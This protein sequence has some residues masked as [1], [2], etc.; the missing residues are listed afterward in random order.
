MRNGKFGTLWCITLAVVLAAGGADGATRRLRRM[1]VVGDSVLAGFSSG[2]F[3]ARGH[4]GQVDSAPAFVARR[5]GVFLPQPLM[6]GPG[7]PAQ[8]AIVDANGNG[9]LDPGD[10]QRTSDNIGFRAKPVRVARNLAIPGEDMVSVFDEIAPGVIARRL[11]EG[12]TVAGRDVLKFLELGLPFRAERVSQVTRA[13]DLNP[14]FLMVWI[15]NND[16]LDM[17][18]ST[19][20]TAVTLDPSEFGRRFRRLLDELAD[21]GA[22]MAVGNIPDVTGVAALRH[23]AGEVTSCRQADGSVRPVA[24]GDLLSIDLERTALPVPP[25]SD[26]LGP[27]ERDQVRATVIAFNAEIAAAIVD[28]EQRRGVSIAPVDLFALFDGLRA[29]GSDVNGD[30]AAD[31]TT[32]Y[33]GGV[34]SLDG[35]H[36]TPTG[37][38]LIANAF[39]DAIQQRF[40]DAVPRV[41]VARVAA[42]DPLVGNSFR[43][44]GEAPFGLFAPE[45]QNDL[46][47]F[48][49]DIFDRVSRGAL[50]F[51]EDVSDLGRDFANRI[52]RFFRDLF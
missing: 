42:R 31:L 14:S 19:N 43:P 12:D 13:R 24:A 41:D 51:R 3:V 36:P 32:G 16:V 4:G 28:T 23:A 38:A 22:D 35:V 44:A 11:V 27:V 18:T 20:P 2:G 21:T 47:G 9:V 26:V 52:K 7:V 17:A 48:F 33:L 8:L 15:G 40:G 25:C 39:L 10:V 5:A 45:D 34:F 30:G 49:D 29:S 50:Q 46:A 37:N 6:S 1:V